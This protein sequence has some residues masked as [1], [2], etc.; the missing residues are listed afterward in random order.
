MEWYPGAVRND[1]LPEKVG[2]SF[3]GEAGPKRGSVLHSAEGYWGGIHSVLFDLD[4]RASWH[5]TIG[6]DRVEQ[7][8]PIDAYCWHAGDVDDD[9]G[10]AANLD[11]V[12]IEHLG[13][14]RPLRLYTPLTAWQA[15][16]TIKLSWWL[17]G[18]FERQRAFVRFPT[19]DLAQ[20]A[21]GVWLLVEHGEVSD[22]FTWCPSNRIHW[23]PIVAELNRAVPEP[24]EDDM[25]I[26]K[27]AR[28]WNPAYTFLIAYIDLGA[29]VPFPIYKVH[30]PTPA[31]VARLAAAVGE[32]DTLTKARLWGIPTID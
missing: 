31:R 6:Y 24:Q 13:I 12:G 16:E 28:Q 5:F 3:V 22:T 20:D 21:E 9:G 10:V 25:T 1:G 19:L 32:P 30:I 29:G 8:Y 4:R 14:G 23:P 11:L 2:Y 7:H 18:Q 26:Y 15:N 17:A 27:L